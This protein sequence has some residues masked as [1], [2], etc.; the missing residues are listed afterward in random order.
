MLILFIDTFKVQTFCMLQYV[1][2]V[3]SVFCIGMHLLHSQVQSIYRKNV[4]IC[5]F[6]YLITLHSVHMM[7]NVHAAHH[8]GHRLLHD[9]AVFVR[10]WKPQQ[11]FNR[12]FPH[13]YLSHFEHVLFDHARS[14]TG[15]FLKNFTYSCHILPI[16]FI[17]AFLSLIMI[18]VTLD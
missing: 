7:V 10:P 18:I 15:D 1:M 5:V 12:E 13:L 9:T 11:Y 16:F 4:S 3:D 2:Y 6:G 8:K 14:L 17:D